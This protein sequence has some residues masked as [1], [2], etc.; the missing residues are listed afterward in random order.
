[1]MVHL[2]MADGMVSGAAHPAAHTIV[3]SFQIIKTAPGTATVSSVFLM[4]LSDRVLRLRRL[5]GQPGS[6]RRAPGRYRDP[7]P[8]THR[9]ARWRPSGHLAGLHTPRLSLAPTPGAG[10]VHADEGDDMTVEAANVRLSVIEQT[11]QAASAE[12]RL[13]YL[14]ELAAMA[15]TLGQ[16]TGPQAENAEWLT[17][18]LHRVVRHIT[19]DPGQH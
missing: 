2:G 7:G 19:H 11:W 4:C 8:T 14:D 13:G 17:R 1:M 3:P 18:R 12:E 6:H 9:H 15:G 5:R 16:V 10:T